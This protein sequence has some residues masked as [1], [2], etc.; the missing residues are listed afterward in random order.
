MK[1]R[2]ERENEF[3]THIMICEFD[4]LIGLRFYVMFSLG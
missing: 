3:N 2:R 4:C 1:V